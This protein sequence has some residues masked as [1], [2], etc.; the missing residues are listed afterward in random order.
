MSKSKARDLAN[1]IALK[2][3]SISEVNI[4]EG[5][6]ISTEELNKLEGVEAPV[7]TQ[8]D[9]KV[10]KIDIVG[11]TVGSSASVPVITFNSQGQITAASTTPV[12]GV[13]SVSFSNSSGALTIN[14]SDGSS[15]LSDLGIGTADAP[16]FSGATINGNIAV[17]GTV[18]G[19]DLAADGTKLDGIE[20][21]ATADQ[22]ITAGSGLTGGGSGDVTISHADT[23]SQASISNSG[24][25]V[26]QSITVDGYGH[27][28]A[29]SSATI[30]TNPPNTAGG[31]G[32]Y[33]FFSRGPNYSSETTSYNDV[34]PGSTYAGSSLYWASGLTFWSGGHRWEDYAS[35]SAI[36]ADRTPDGG[37]TTGTWRCMGW[38]DPYAT[39]SPGSQQAGAGT[40]FI[41]I[42]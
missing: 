34:S 31:V 40:L 11:A 27:I 13:S 16:T 33:G 6:T 19:R 17:T 38:S 37:T 15:Y 1:Y 8:L 24:N 12:A 42:S 26:I 4:L 22:T 32:T 41:R 20:A 29:V 9:A 5:A 14:T 21:G 36:G 39:G 23:S 10:D 2:R 7:Q 30:S 35:S 3:A 18:D 28:T 25:T